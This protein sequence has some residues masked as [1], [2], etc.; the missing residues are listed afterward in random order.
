MTFTSCGLFD[1]VAGKE[2][3][4]STG[5]WQLLRYSF[6]VAEARR[7]GRQAKFW[8]SP[9][10]A[11]GPE[12]NSSNAEPNRLNPTVDVDL[13]IAGLNWSSFAARP[14]APR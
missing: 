8:S 1:I 7:S 14:A 11:N 3:L 12:P 13:V 9:T 2:T 6:A 10:G 4:S 5:T